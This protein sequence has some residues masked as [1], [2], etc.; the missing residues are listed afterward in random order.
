MSA[1]ELDAELAA[2][3]VF[4]GV[5]DDGQLRGVMGIR[6]VGDVQLI[7]YA[8]V[9]PAAQRR[10]FG[11]ALLDHLMRLTTGPALVGTWA[12]AQCAVA[13]YLRQGFERVSDQDKTRLLRRC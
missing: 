1:A 4:H 7:R 3:I 9:S 10:G 12:A 6:D 13:F 2:G 11:G 8:Y 5:Q